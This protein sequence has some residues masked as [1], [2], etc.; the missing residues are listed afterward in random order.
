MPRAF[1]ETRAR[2]AVADARVIG[3][4]A[5]A[6]KAGVTER[7]LHNWR[8]HLE[9]GA[10]RPVRM[11]TGSR[12]TGGPR[13]VKAAEPVSGVERDSLVKQLQVQRTRL[14]NVLA[15]EKD[16]EAPK[17]ATT[18]LIRDV[19]RLERELAELDAEAS[20]QQLAKDVVGTEENW[21][22]SAGK[23]IGL[24]IRRMQELIS[25]ERDL[26]RVAEATGYIIEA[27]TAREAFGLDEAD[28]PRPDA[29]EVG[30]PA[31]AACEGAGSES[32]ADSAGERA[33][34]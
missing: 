20:V 30:S 10:L 1:P 32:D 26:K 28:Q 22:C 17:T 15:R 8:K 18:E 23:L 31:T 5:A 6:K 24:G 12:S 16:G 34:S 33:D 7:T 2:K 13:A 25:Q 14:Q 9:A 19:A 11:Q 3:Y 21:Q 27:M 29:G 4:A